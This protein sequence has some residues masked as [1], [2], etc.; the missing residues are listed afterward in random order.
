MT[1][2][3]GLAIGGV[4][5]VAQVL[6]TRRPAPEP[7]HTCWASVGEDDWYFSPDQAQNVALFAA[8]AAERRLPARAVTI[9]IATAMQ[10]SR[11]VNID[12]GDRD[13]VG[14]FQQRPSQGWGSVEQIMDPVYS[15][16][17]F[18]DGLVKVRDYTSLDVTVA[19]QA[20]QRS[21]FPDAYAQHEGR[22]RAWA[23]ALTAQDGADLT[24]ELR[25]SLPGGDVRVFAKRASRDMPSASVTADAATRTVRL[26]PGSLAGD[27]DRSLA[28]IAMWAVAV[29]EPGQVVSVTLGDRT[30]ERATGA[31]R[32]VPA[33]SGATT[34]ASSPNAVTVALAP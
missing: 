32:T 3:V 4:W 13:S 15:T 17:K 25:P 23:S 2:T 16:G 19:A 5:A 10:E 8:M 21:G 26:S 11:A 30:W 24:C 29:A 6:D 18:Y 22:A 14:L 12:Y 31:W 20:V 28:R 1:A 27:H 33:P 9:A 34:P 7:R